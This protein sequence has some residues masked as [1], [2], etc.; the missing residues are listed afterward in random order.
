MT[1]RLCSLLRDLSP[2]MSGEGGDGDGGFR[3]GILLSRGRSHDTR[4]NQEVLVP[5]GEDETHVD[6]RQVLGFRSWLSVCLSANV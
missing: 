3:I 6:V 4:S 2:E 1:H 5:V